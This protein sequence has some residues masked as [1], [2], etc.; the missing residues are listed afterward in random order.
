MKKDFIDIAEEK[1]IFMS[2]KAIRDA[3][4]KKHKG[5]YKG[6]DIFATKYDNLWYAGNTSG[7]TEIAND[8]IELLGVIYF[9]KKWKKYI[10]EQSPRVMLAQ[11]C[12]RKI[13]KIIDLIKKETKE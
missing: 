3:L 4:Y 2:F 13:D 1:G 12:M 5:M 9:Y 7:F 11:N 8:K 10:W 6:V